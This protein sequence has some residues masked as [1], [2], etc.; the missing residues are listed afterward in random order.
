MSDGHGPAI[1]HRAL[2]DHRNHLQWWLERMGRPRG[3]GSVRMVGDAVHLAWV[4]GPDP[5]EPH[6]RC[7]MRVRA[8]RASSQS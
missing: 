8:G 4:A 6:D 2:H 7:R 1:D 3:R 5:A